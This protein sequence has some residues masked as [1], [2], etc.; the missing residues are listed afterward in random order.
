MNSKKHNTKLRMLIA[1]LTLFALL[2]PTFSSYAAAGGG[3]VAEP[4][5]IVSGSFS[6][7]ETSS[8]S[9]RAH[10]FANSSGTASYIT[11]KVTLQSASLG[12]SSYSTVSGLSPSIYTVYEKNCIDHICSF[13]ITS[14]K[15]Y[16]IKI[17]ITDKVNGKISTTTTYKTLTRK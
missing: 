1:L 12:S 16:R 9:A 7:V 13:P 2:L 14:S 3:N 5:T 8:N 6:F 4:A 11:S 10:I 17:D 15:N